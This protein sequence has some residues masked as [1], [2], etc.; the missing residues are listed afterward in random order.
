MNESMEEA[1]VYAKKYIE[2]LLSF[3]G[4]NTDVY[5]TSDD[6]VI[7]LNVPSTHMNGF[8]IGQH[9]DNM[10]SLQYLTSTALK[11]NNFAN[12]RVN[13][14]IAEYKKQRADRLRDKAEAWVKQVRDSGSAMDLEPMNA[15]DRRVVHQLAADYG[16]SSESAG[17]GRERHIVLKPTSE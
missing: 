12:T 16:L 1:I 8:L 2:D 11:N 17:E 4:L 3:F 15:A 5:A 7:Q 9:G 14:D 10:R 6:E 13:V